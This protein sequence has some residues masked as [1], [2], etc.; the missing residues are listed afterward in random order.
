MQVF[1]VRELVDQ[2]TKEPKLTINVINPGLA[3]TALTRHATGGIKWAIGLLKFLMAR[4][5]EEASRT[6]VHAALA[7]PETNGQYISNCDPSR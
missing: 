4:T 2:M 5:A 1:A 6:L 3:K 7:G